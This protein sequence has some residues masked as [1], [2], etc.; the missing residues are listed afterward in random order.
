M[1]VTFPKD[2]RKSKT[3]WISGEYRVGG[4]SI[5]DD[6][7]TAQIE[8]WI[9]V[10][11][12]RVCIIIQIHRSLLRIFIRFLVKVDMLGIMVDLYEESW[13]TRVD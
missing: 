1:D 9:C 10:C 11:A 2:D 6:E 12:L 8:D 3:I 4:V 7:Q 5:F 13:G